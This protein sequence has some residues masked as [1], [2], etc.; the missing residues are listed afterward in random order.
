M[1]LF[2]QKLIFYS[3]FYWKSI[4]EDRLQLSSQ[5]KAISKIRRG[6]VEYFASKLYILD[7]FTYN[8][9][10]SLDSEKKGHQELFKY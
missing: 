7:N 8:M 3:K 10:Q 9:Q 4:S 1:K 2:L 6:K 5:K